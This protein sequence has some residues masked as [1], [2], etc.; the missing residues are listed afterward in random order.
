VIHQPQLVTSAG[1]VSREKTAEIPGRPGDE[2]DRSGH[3]SAT[4]TLN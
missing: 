2:N 1:E 4:Q 3:R